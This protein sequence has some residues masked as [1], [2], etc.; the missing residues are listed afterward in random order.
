[1]G[2]LGLG[3]R[4]MVAHWRMKSP[5]SHLAFSYPSPLNDHRMAWI[6]AFDT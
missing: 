6:R 1:M 3:G 4:G 2:T 5:M